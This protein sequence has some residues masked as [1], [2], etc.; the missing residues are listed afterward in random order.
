M[1]K[2]CLK[3]PLGPEEDN[4]SCSKGPIFGLVS[5]NNS[6]INTGIMFQAHAAK[7]IR[8]GSIYHC[9]VGSLTNWLTLSPDYLKKKD[10]KVNVVY[11]ENF[12]DKLWAH[13]F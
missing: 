9:I 5:F 6:V 2:G 8:L 4:L 12:C 1:S 13:Q 11:L 3:T 7:R 10:T